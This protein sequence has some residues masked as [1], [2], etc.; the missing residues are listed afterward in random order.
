MPGQDSSY[1]W[2]GMIPQDENPFQYNPERGFVSSANQRPTDSTYPYYL[3]RE[4]PTPR[5][6]IINRRL[7]QM[8]QVTPQDMMRLQTDNYN[9]FAEMAR[10]VFLKNI[11]G[12]LSDAEK[13]YFDLL[14]QWDL[15]NDPNSKGA[16]VFHLAWNHFKAKVFNDEFANAPKPI[17]IPFESTLLEAVLKDS[18]Y[19]FIDDVSTPRVESIADITTAAFKEAA[20]EL[21]DYENQGRLEWSK[22]KDTRVN[23]LTKLPALSRLHLPIGGGTNIINATKEAHG[24]SWRMIVSLTPQTEAYGVYPGGQSGNPGSPFYDNFIDTWVAGKYYPLWVMTKEEEK[25][26]R[27]KWTLT[28]KNGSK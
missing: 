8:N 4:Y 7:A 3:G 15:R 23:H 17:L 11:S 22:F 27:V 26:P 20:A 1:Q 14:A 5:G 12:G 2:Q 19:K 25:D 13:K 28:F 21:A 18:A 16:T 6:L 9:V 24:P 10:P